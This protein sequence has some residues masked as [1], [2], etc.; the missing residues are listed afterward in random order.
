MQTLTLEISITKKK[1][2]KQIKEGKFDFSTI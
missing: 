2:L 1:C